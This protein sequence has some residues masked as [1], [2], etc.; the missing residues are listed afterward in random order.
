[1]VAN[2]TL[3]SKLKVVQNKAVQ[4]IYKL[5]PRSSSAPILKT[6]HW[7]PIRKWPIF[8]LSC[9]THKVLNKFLPA[10]LHSRLCHYQPT[11]LLSSTNKALL[12]IPRIRTSRFGGRS[13]S[14]LAHSIGTNFLLMFALIL[15][16]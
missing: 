9:L 16:L 10:Y 14:Y 8:K 15:V 3:L 1:M 5:P 4:L 11:R 7:L 6:L 2:D 13:F 12:K